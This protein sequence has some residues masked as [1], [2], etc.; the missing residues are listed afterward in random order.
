MYITFCCDWNMLY[1]SAYFHAI[2][3]TELFTVDEN[4]RLLFISVIVCIINMSI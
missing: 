4:Y 2:T 1:N 3:C